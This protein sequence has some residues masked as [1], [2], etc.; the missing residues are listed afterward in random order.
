M[1]ELYSFILGF[2]G[3]ILSYIILTY[4]FPINY[5]SL[6]YDMNAELEVSPHTLMMTK[7]TGQKYY[8]KEFILVDLRSYEEYKKE[9]IIDSV[10]I[11]GQISEQ[12][13]VKRFQDLRNQ[14]PNADI[15]TFCYSSSCT[16]SKKVGKILAKH[17]IYVK[18]LNVGWLELRY[19]PESWN[20]NPDITPE[21]YINKTELKESCSIERSC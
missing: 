19:F 17:G 4:L 1:K 8:P 3:G 14:Y 12:E 20:T 10:N 7:L 9:R 18:H 13:L 11:P 5:Y 21:K 6:Y 2:L 16:L 15:I